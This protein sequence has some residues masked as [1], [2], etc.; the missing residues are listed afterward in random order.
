MIRASA[1]YKKNNWD[2]QL[3]DFEVAFKPAVNS[4]T[5]CS[6]FFI[7]YGVHPKLIPLEG[8]LSNNPTAKSLIDSIHDTSRFA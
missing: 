1:N 7:N 3:V 4:T 5:L 2:E 6:A 8:L